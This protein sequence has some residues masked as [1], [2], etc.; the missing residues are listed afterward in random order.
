MA[1]SRVGVGLVVGC[2]LL[3]G[4]SPAWAVPPTVKQML[5]YRPR[6]EGV[7]IS[8][9]AP[10]EYASCKVKLV[11]GGRP[12]SSGWLLLDSGDRPLRRFFDSNGDKQIDVWS[13]YKDG[14]EVYREID[15][16]FG[17]RPGSR[18]EDPPAAN[19]DQYRWLHSAGMKSG[20][21]V[22]EDGKIDGWKMI[23]AVEAAQE[24]Y[25]AVRANDYARLQALFLTES[26]LQAL[27]L[28]TDKAEEVRKRMQQAP[29]K[30]KAAAEKLAAFG[31]VQLVQVDGVVPQCVPADVAGTQRDLFKHPSRGVLF[32][33]GDKDSK[34]QEWLQTGEMIQVG[35]AWRLTDGPT[36]G[37]IFDNTGGGKETL[38]PEGPEI[39]PLLEKLAELDKTP[40]T[41]PP[42]P[43]PRPEVVR[44]FRQRAEIVEQIVAKLNK[45]APDKAATWVRQWA[46]NLSTAAQHAAGAEAEALL[47]RLKQMRDQTAQA[48]AG[49]SLA[50]YLTYKILWTEYNP[51][52]V[53]GNT[54]AQAQWLE[55]LTSFVQSYPRADDTPD[56]LQYLGMGAEFAGKDDEAKR[57]YK[58]LAANFADKPQGK[59]AEGAL[60]RLDLVGK[61][62][63]LTGQTNSGQSFE[64]GSLKGKVVAVYYWASYGTTRGDDFAKLKQ[65]HDKLG[66]KGFEVV[67]VNLD[68]QPEQGQAALQSASLPG[69]HLVQPAVEGGGMN[70]PLATQYGILGVPSLFVVGKDG[71]VLSRNMSIS[72]LE[73]AV[74]KAVSQ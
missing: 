61:E 2:L 17:R 4:A 51:K 35:M 53:K 29:A 62:M 25:Q 40:P 68:D 48:A 46:D 38:P 11:T 20:V 15:S 44:Y 10:E 39:Q 47:G 1:K 65:V 42:T 27:G 45:S 5:A 14:V 34:K 37:A 28:P 60:R 71:K 30:F 13:Y 54:E 73:E 23:S 7:A 57:W 72:G 49:S 69:A 58:Q 12:G 6:Q 59:R 19:A 3:G 22:N 31:A 56:A 66:A 43:E 32:E 21:D 33:Y 55:K 50:G 36:I 64:L 74:Q 24:A 67:T 16:K 70:S 9:P 26:D 63:E 8:T 18:P 41:L 52:L